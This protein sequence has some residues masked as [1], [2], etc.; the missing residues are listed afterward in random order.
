M[1]AAAVESV[2]LGIGAGVGP[3]ADIQVR[4]PAALRQGAVDGMG[5]DHARLRS[6]IAAGDVHRQVRRQV[7]QQADERELG[8]GPG[9]RGADH[10]VD[11]RFAELAADDIG[12]RLAVDQ[13]RRPDDIHRL[14]VGRADLARR[15][16]RRWS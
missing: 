5:I 7:G 6:A 9:V 1:R 4:Q 10:G 2:G 16:G 14:A 8:E 11:A 3:G 13:Q 15:P 12:L